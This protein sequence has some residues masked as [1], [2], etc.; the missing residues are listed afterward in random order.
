MKSIV[1]DILKISII[2]VVY[3][4]GIIVGFGF[5]IGLIEKRASYF[6][7]RAIGFKGVLITGLIGTPIHEIGHFLMC[8]IFGHTVTEVKLLRPKACKQDGVLG[9]VK[10]SFNKNS[11]YQNIGNFFIAIGPLV[12]GSLTMF[13]TMKIFLSDSFN[14]LYNFLLNETKLVHI[15]G[16]ESFFDIFKSIFNE[17]VKDIFNTNN[18]KTINFWIFLFI[19]ISIAS[20]MALSKADIK[21][22]ISGLIAIYTFSLILSIILNLA[23]FNIHYIYSKILVFNIFISVFLIVALIFSFIP[24]IVNLILYLIKR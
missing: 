14:K 16:E 24:L 9:Y 13:L 23:N 6:I 18:L 21:G 3:T 7:Q 1:F 22:G 5:I 19:I 15:G 11:L 12:F 10:H 2:Q 17:V 8:I 4:L 20:H